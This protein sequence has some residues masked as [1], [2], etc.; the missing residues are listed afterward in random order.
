MDWSD[1]IGAGGVALIL[2]AFVLNLLGRMDRGDRSYL[3][4][5]LLG[6]GLACAS[7]VMIGFVPFVVLEGVWAA[8]ALAGLLGALPTTERT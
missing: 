6:A 4:L 5:N 1:V 7:S 2:L 8:V 3:L